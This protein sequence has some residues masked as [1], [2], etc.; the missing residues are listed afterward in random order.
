MIDELIEVK[1]YNNISLL[2]TFTSCEQ[3]ILDINRL[4]SIQHHQLSETIKMRWKIMY[5]QG[6]FF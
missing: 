3:R 2:L 1:P 4:F 6:E 5:D